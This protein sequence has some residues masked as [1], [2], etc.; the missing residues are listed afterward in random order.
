MKNRINLLFLLIS[1]STFIQAAEKIIMASSIFASGINYTELELQEEGKNGF[2]PLYYETLTEILDSS[3]ITPESL[4]IDVLR[5]PGMAKI[6]IHRK[7]NP[8]KY[9]SFTNTIEIAPL[10]DEYSQ[11]INSSKNSIFAFMDLPFSKILAAQPPQL[12]S[13]RLA[14]AR[15]WMDSLIINRISKIIANSETLTTPEKLIV[16]RIAHGTNS[17][18]LRR[19]NN[20]LLEIE[21]YE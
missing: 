12:P 14:Q 7:I 6:T 5:L 17:G 8:N 1:C 9:F 16:S 11:A 3:K 13:E 20:T 18:N 4:E 10:D 15:N 19:T 21:E 2:M